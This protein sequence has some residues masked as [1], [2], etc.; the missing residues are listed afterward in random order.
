MKRISGIGASPGTAT[1]SAY[2]FRPDVY[3]LPSGAPAD[4]DKAVAQLAAALDEVA[5]D[6]E[7]AGTRT[8]GDA[9]DIL[10]AQAEIAR[11]P[12]LRAAAESAVTGGEQPASAILAAGARFARELEATG[13]DYLAARA[14]DVRHICELA[15]R[16]LAGAPPRLPPKPVEPCI[17]VAEDLTPSDTAGLDPALVRG[18]AIA[19]GSKTSHASVIARGLGIPAV[20]GARGLMDSIPDRCRI[21][22]DGSSGEVFVEPDDAVVKALDRSAEAARARRNRMRSLAG[23]QPAATADGHRVEIA[24]NVRS[25]EEARAA[26]AEGAEGIGLLRTELLY[27]DRDRPPSEE[28]QRELFE[29]LHGLLGGRRLVVRTFDIG[30]DKQVPF[31][32]ARPET[33]PELGVRGLRL[34][35]VHE[36]LLLV[37]LR[38]IAA[39]AERGPTA[40]MA[41]MVGSP[42]EGRW[43][44]E[45]A[46]GAGLKPPVELGVMVEVPALLFAID[47][48]PDEIS[49]LSVGTND[50]TQYLY[51]ADRRHPGLAHLQDPF[52]P[53]V[54][55][56]VDLI[57]RHATQRSWI[58][59]CGEAA[60]DPAWALVA[61][62]LGVTELSMHPSAIAEVRAAL[63]M[64][65]F[66]RCREIALRCL[67]SRDAASARATAM[68][69]TEG[70]R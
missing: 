48:L 65:T 26:M 63:R 52:L 7:E 10:F 14:P 44:I 20:V 54:L 15:S 50:L 25:V 30:A 9:R 18:I 43:F 69:L 2:V 17:I 36:D 5:M 6:L 28:E 12:A 68:E 46:I 51:A 4:V 31:L 24:A 64:E 40:V 21:A 11:D 27:V 45:R 70:L 49:F 23:E 1:G 60:S 22:I 62:G 33:N 3:E 13:N 42:D 16:A 38:A 59:V 8:E 19:S 34:A 37:Q 32:P 58:G 66:A 41:P 55:R 61:V 39:A 57:S 67:R 47:E 35:Q 53:A 29:E 56:A